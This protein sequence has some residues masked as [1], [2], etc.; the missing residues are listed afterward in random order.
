MEIIS[1]IVYSFTF[2]LLAWFSLAGSMLIALFEGN[3]H[4][5]IGWVVAM[6]FY[7]IIWIYE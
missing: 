5:L 3:I 6:G 2:R 7:L 4:A 1:K